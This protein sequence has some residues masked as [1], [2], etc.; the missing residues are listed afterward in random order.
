MN[1]ID[2]AYELKII[3]MIIDKFL[4]ESI[5]ITDESLSEL[6]TDCDQ[7]VYS[8]A[9]K[10]FNQ[11]GHK[12]EFSMIRDIIVS[13]IEIIKSQL[14]EKKSAEAYRVAVEESRF[15]AEIASILSEFEG[16]E[17]K[18]EVF[19]RLRRLISYELNIYESQILLD[20]HITNDL[21]V[22]DCDSE[23][24]IEAIGEEFLETGIDRDLLELFTMPEYDGSPYYGPIDCTVRELLDFICKKL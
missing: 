4:D 22:D 21:G 8:L 10:I 14:A 19:V 18:S 6:E 1:Q 13:R 15:R 5:S 7:I 20:S 11:S 9:I 16:N 24:I 12:V 23:G 3:K 2:K 17:I